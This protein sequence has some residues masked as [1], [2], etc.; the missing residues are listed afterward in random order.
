MK[1]LFVCLIDSFGDLQDDILRKE[2][3]I[4]SK[5]KLLMYEEATDTSKGKLDDLKISIRN[6][7]N[8]TSETIKDIFLKNGVS[9]QNLYEI[10]DD[11]FLFVTTTGSQASF[12]LND[13]WLTLNVGGQLFTTTRTTLARE[14]D[15]FFGRMFAPEFQNWT[16]RKINGAI[17]IDR[18]HRYFDVI[19][20]YLRYNLVLILKYGKFNI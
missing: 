11:D 19:L 18:S 16:H 15:S 3:S 12:S 5:A 6:I 20:D 9:V 10:R 2:K 7:F 17:M 8:L 13:E 4:T 14:P 1:R